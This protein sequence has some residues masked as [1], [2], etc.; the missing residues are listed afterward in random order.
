MPPS[1]QQVQYSSA[2]AGKYGACHLLASRDEPWQ[3]L[4]TDNEINTKDSSTVMDDQEQTARMPCTFLQDGVSLLV[5]PMARQTRGWSDLHFHPQLRLP[6]S[7]SQ[8]QGMTILLEGRLSL[9]P[10]LIEQTDLVMAHRFSRCSSFK[11]L[12]TSFLDALDST[13]TSEIRNSKPW[14]R[15]V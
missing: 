8:P 12:Q 9:L 1:Y 3:F 4:T 15:N 6:E 14:Q 11:T 5:L 10:G 2:F 7:Q 13:P